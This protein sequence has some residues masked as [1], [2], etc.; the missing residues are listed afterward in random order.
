MLS[1]A[2]FIVEGDAEHENFKDHTKNPFHQ[3]LTQHGWQHQSTEHKKNPFAKDNPR[4]DST[5]HRYTHPKHGKSTVDVEQEHDT[6]I[7]HGGRKTKTSDFL[8][9]HVQDNGIVA[10]SRGDSKPQLH[11]EL[12]YHYGVPK[13][14]Q[15]PKLTASEK[16]YPH[17]APHY[18]MNE[19]FGIGTK[20]L[21]RIDVHNTLTSHGFH[22]GNHGHRDPTAYQTSYTHPKHNSSVNIPAGNNGWK[23]NHGGQTYKGKTHGELQGALQKHGL[24][25]NEA[26]PQ[27][28]SWGSYNPK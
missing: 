8:H 27:H 7:G 25:S 15:A 9:R 12:S 6:S 28:V 3:I 26:S 10:P 4:A 1:F 24:A 21:N 5:V 20:S 16:K 18:K 14:M 23:L 13:G 22:G 11:Q 19:I 2:Q 17:T